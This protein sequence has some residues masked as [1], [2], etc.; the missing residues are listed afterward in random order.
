MHS[1]GMM[2]LLSKRFRILIRWQYWY[3]TKQ[4]GLPDRIVMLLCVQVE[5]LLVTELFR[6]KVFPLIAKKVN[7]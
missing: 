1:R 6:E 2:S 5:E 7:K 3:L 4:F